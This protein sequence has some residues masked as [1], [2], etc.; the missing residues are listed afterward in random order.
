M[1]C[2]SYTRA[3]PWRSLENVLSIPEQ[4]AKIDEF[5][6][7]HPECKLVK[8]YAERKVDA[9]A[10]DVFQQMMNDITAWK[11]DCVIFADFAYFGTDYPAFN[12][13]IGT[14][15]YPA[16]LHFA[17]ASADFL[18]SDHLEKEVKEYQDV[19]HHL[20]HGDKFLKW[21]ATRKE[22]YILTNSVPYGY[23]RRNGSQVIEKDERVAEYVAGVF[24]LYQ[25]GR[26]YSEIAKWLNE[27]NAPTPSVNRNAVGTVTQC[28]ITKKWSNESVKK[29]LK[30]PIYAGIVVNARREFITDGTYEPYISREAFEALPNYI[31]VKTGEKQKRRLCAKV[32]E[33]P[34]LLATKIYNDDTHIFCK[35]IKGNDE[36]ESYFCEDNRKESLSD[37]A[38]WKISV[39]EVYDLVLQAV[40]LEK[41][42]AECVADMIEDGKLE[43]FRQD[44]ENELKRKL[45]TCLAEMELE[46]FQRVP[47]YNEF[48]SGNISEKDYKKKLEE[49]ADAHKCQDRIFD[50]CMEAMAD[51]RKVYSLSNPWIKCFTQLEIGEKLDRNIVKTAVEWVV[52]HVDEKNHVQVVPKLRQQEYWEK[53]PREIREECSHGKNQ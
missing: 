49:Y 32:R 48:S 31:P 47:L 24:R 20:A 52:L 41:K 9:G 11:Y 35:I 30:N 50:E 34:N 15:I 37:E 18:S 25:D 22:E 38:A 28:A 43:A 3:I 27:H 51:N 23:L 12:A 16:R 44:R 42:K 45:K 4:N 6:K 1:R 26:S 33:F 40:M 53:L 2:V 5:I 39:N 7:K 46:Q 14:V 21:R 29:I 10:D 36:Q 17:D 13:A 8:K 19:V